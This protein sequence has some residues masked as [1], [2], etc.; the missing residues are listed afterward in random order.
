M[1]KVELSFRPE[2]PVAD[3]AAGIPARL[4]ATA[5]TRVL[6]CSRLGM[7]ANPGG[8]PRVWLAFPPLSGAAYRLRSLRITST[9]VSTPMPA[10][11]IVTAGFCTNASARLGVVGDPLRVRTLSQRVD[12]RRQLIA[13][14]IDLLHDL[15]RIPIRH[16]VLHVQAV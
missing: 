9:T 3:V 5:P 7:G 14:P 13:S 6:N 2:L 16:A 11:E 15:F 12:R 1:D 10:S 4:T 8:A